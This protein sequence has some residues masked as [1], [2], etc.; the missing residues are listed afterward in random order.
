MPTLTHWSASLLVVLSCLAGGCLEIVTSQRPTQG[1]SQAALNMP[2][3]VVMRAYARYSFYTTEREAELIC[4]IALPE[5]DLATAVLVAKDATGRKLATAKHVQPRMLLSIPIARLTPGPMAVTIEL[6]RTDGE[7][8]IREEVALLKRAPKLGR[9]WKIDHANKVILNNG[10]PFFPFGMMVSSRGTTNEA[11]MLKDLADAGFNSVARFGGSPFNQIEELLDMAQEH[12]LYV[13]DFPGMWQY[14][15]AKDEDPMPPWPAGVSWSHDAV[16]TIQWDWLMSHVWLPGIERIMNHPNL[17]GYYLRDEPQSA[18]LMAAALLRFYKAINDLDGYHPS[19]VLYIPPIPKGDEF[20]SNCDILGIDPYWIPGGGKSATDNPL[21]VGRHTWETRQRA[22]R[23]VKIAWITPCAEQYSVTRMRLFVENEQRVQTYLSLINGAK[24]LL[25]FVYPFKHQSTY[26]TFVRLGREMKILGPACAARDI[27]QTI[28]YSP[29]AFE[30]LKGKYPDVQVSL[31]KNPAGGYILLAANWRPYPVDVTVTLPWSDP[32]DKS[33]LSDTVRHLFDGG[34]THTLE[35]GS[36]TDSLAAMDTRAYALEG[37]AELTAPVAIAV[38]VKAYPEQTDAFLTARGLPDSGA[39]GNKNILRNSG[40]ESC[41]IPGM[42]DY[43][44]DMRTPLTKLGYRQGDPRG[45]CGW[46]I[47]TNQPFEGKNCLRLQDSTYS[48][49]LFGVSPKLD[50]TTPFVFSTWA[51][52]ESP[53]NTYLLFYGPGT[54]RKRIALTNTWTR[55]SQ[56]VTLTPEI[57]WSGHYFGFH[58]GN[59][60]TNNVWLDAM[61]MEKGTNV[62]DYAP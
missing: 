20:T 42:P 40:F 12:G 19:E 27:P 37:P 10:E 61:Q 62:T 30:P 18:R 22:D 1:V 23:D 6:Q 36:F 11:I 29:A 53:T 47:D 26:N 8:I 46:S 58:T 28:R 52:S 57:P 51:R 44:K 7:P 17:I 25:Y 60:G 13:M 24:G 48:F 32:S 55:H 16:A 54:E 15:P 39:P 49:L 3:G 50:V 9:E 43:Y 4:E 59:T 34:A 45:T 21:C 41:S 31:K 35:H 5:A 38:D 33:D 2:T 56:T 14:K